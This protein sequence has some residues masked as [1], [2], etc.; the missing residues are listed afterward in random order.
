MQ[1]IPK[2]N[3]KYSCNIKQE[4]KKH[5]RL[6][7]RDRY[8]EAIHK[9]GNKYVEIGSALLGI[10]KRKQKQKPKYYL[11]RFKLVKLA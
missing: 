1:Y 11:T 4:G 9:N 3:F 7:K 10:L 8:L 2:I 6:D 5:N